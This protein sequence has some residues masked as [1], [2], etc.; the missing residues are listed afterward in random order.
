MTSS[1]RAE[2][3]ALTSIRK[4]IRAAIRENIHDT[5]ISEMIITA[6]ISI[7]ITKKR[8]MTNAAANKRLIQA[9]SIARLS[10]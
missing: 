6:S 4:K 5:K 2:S 9:N 8:I 1:L 7:N 3:E 10:S